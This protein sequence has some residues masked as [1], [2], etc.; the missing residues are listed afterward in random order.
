MAQRLR[1]LAAFA[2][3]LGSVPSIQMAPSNC[4]Q[5]HQFQEIQQPLWQAWYH[6]H[7]WLSLLSTMDHLP[8]GGT[9]HSGLDPPTSLDN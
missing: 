3:E 9:T 6:Y 8:K 1:A 7:T 5:Y 2:E 4:L